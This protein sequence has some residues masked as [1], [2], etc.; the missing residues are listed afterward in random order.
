MGGLGVSRFWRQRLAE[1]AEADFLGFGVLMTVDLVKGASIGSS[2]SY[3][4]CF[5]L[6]WRG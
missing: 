5:W 2:V 1:R 6:I 3:A 4:G